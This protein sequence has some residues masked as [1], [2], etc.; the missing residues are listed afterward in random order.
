MHGDAGQDLTW[1]D[2]EKKR[3][4]RSEIEFVIMDLETREY[5]QLITSLLKV[6][7]TVCLQLAVSVMWT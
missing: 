4:K 2:A 3:L 6:G 1:K 7:I 5:G